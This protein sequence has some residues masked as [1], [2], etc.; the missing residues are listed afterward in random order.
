MTATR[1]PYPANPFGDWDGTPGAAREL[2]K[3]LAEQVRLEDE[4]PAQLRLIAGVDV[5]FEEGGALTR[6]AVVLLDADSLEVVAQSLARIPT[7]MPYVPGLLS[8]RELPAVLQ[9]LAAL[10][11][12]PD[13]IFADGHGIAHPRRLGIAAHLGVVTGLPTIGVAKKIL[14]GDHEPLGEL[15]GEQVP[16]R[17]RAGEIIGTLLRSKDRVRPLIVSPGNRVSLTSA[18]QL[19]M[20][21]VTRYRLPEPTRLADRLASRREEKA[22]ARRGG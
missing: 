13:L 5:G 8:F 22:A 9:A 12:I 17:D 16:L 4:L 6:A 19:V 15:R 10:P 1:S 7:T 3:R 11:A 21:Y 14:C 2:Q 18:P 20:R